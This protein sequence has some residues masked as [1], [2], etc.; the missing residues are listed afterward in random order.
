MEQA[1]IAKLIV[2]IDNVST[3]F[4]ECLQSRKDFNELDS[5]TYN[6]DCRI[7]TSCIGV[8]GLCMDLIKIIDFD[9]I[10]KDLTMND[11]KNMKDSSLIK[12]FNDMDDLRSFISSDETGTFKPI[13]REAITSMFVSCKILIAV[14]RLTSL[15]RTD[16]KN[17][18]NLCSAM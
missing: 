18:Y 15:F 11:R 1:D 10:L 4:K 7:F 3:K 8:L 9:V 12:L 16:Y 17:L 13:D 14:D 6:D 2:D 5:G